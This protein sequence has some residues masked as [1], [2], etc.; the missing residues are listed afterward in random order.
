[1]RKLIIAAACMMTVFAAQSQ[2]LITQVKPAGDKQWG[3]AN[4]KGEMVIPAQYAKCYRFSPEGLAAIYDQKEKQYHFI[5]LKNDRLQV[6]VSQFKLRDGMGF[7]VEGFCDGMAMVKIGDKWGY[8]NTSGKV[9]I[10]AKYDEASDFY[11]GVAN[12]KLGNKFIILNTKGEEIPVESDVIDIKDFSE[13]LAP[14][15]ASNKKFGFVGTDGKIAIKALYESVG[16]FSDGLAWAKD[17]DL[18]GYINNK[19]EWI[20]KPQFTAGKEFDKTSGMARVKNGDKW[21]YVNKAGEM[22]YVADTESWGDFS[23]GLAEGKKNDKK[24][25]FD[26]KGTWVIQPQ[27][28]GVRDFKNGY[29]AAKMG[30]KWGIIDKQ[31]KWVLQP[32]YDG[33]KDMELVK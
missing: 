27:F 15:R 20:I 18:L 19:G 22:M 16:Y 29:A 31:G 13:K 33:I 17:G 32:Q 5:N 24:G 4:I 9:A 2:T 3:Y 30:D 1:M 6:E 12:A 7:D 26:K 23:E 10:A 25:F 14:F 11:A 21:C 28:D 8:I